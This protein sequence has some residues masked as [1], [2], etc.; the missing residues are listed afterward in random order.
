MKRVVLLAAGSFREG[1]R[2][3]LQVHTG[4]WTLSEQPHPAFP[5]GHV[6]ADSSPSP[7]LLSPKQS[8]G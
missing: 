3:D 4:H 7:A 5:K 8:P 1:P 2:A 6:A